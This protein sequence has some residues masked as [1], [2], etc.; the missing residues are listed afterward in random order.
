MFL[1]VN[2]LCSSSYFEEGMYDELQILQ[3]VA[4]SITKLAVRESRA[5]DLRNEILNSEK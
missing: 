5:Q 2:Y 3:D 1:K 4:K